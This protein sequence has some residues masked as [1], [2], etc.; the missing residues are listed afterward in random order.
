MGDECPIS[1]GGLLTTAACDAAGLPAYALEGSIFV[2]G[3]AV[4]WLRDELGLIRNAAETDPI[5]RSV[6][7]TGGVY[8]V[9][10]F[11]GLGAPHWDMDARG[12]IVGLTRGSSRAHLVRATLESIAF[13]TLDVIEVMNREAGIRV[14][15]LRVDGGAAANDFLMQFQA[16]IL[17][18]PVDRPAL[19]ETT[20]AGAAFL[21]GLAVGFWQDPHELAGAR[22]RE[23][24]FEPKMREDVRSRLCAGWQEAVARVRSRGP[25]EA[26]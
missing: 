14:C 13:Q 10:A 24:L 11:A 3:A 20:A 16:D 2:A 8:V 9:P 7:D 1:S 17:G 18:V 23:R 4:Q 5:A 15:E 6:P 26:S 19:L 12:A 22:R 21:A 25:E